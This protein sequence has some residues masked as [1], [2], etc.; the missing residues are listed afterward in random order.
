[1]LRRSGSDGE[2]VSIS[3]R[4]YVIV[5]DKTFKNYI[6]KDVARCVMLKDKIAIRTRQ[7]VDKKI[8]V[9]DFHI[10]SVWPK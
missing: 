5:N 10:E 7:V 2:T 9:I 1:M 4:R 3:V 8:S 6:V